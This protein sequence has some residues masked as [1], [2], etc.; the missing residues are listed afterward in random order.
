MIGLRIKGYKLIETIPYSAKDRVLAFWV[1]QV[2]R[3]NVR[4][5]TY[6]GRR[7]RRMVAIYVRS[8]RNPICVDCG[9]FVPWED[10]IPV[11]LDS[12][13]AY[14]CQSCFR[15]YAYRNPTI[16]ETL[17]GK[18]KGLYEQFH[19]NPP[20]RTRKVKIRV[21]NKGE[22]LVAIGKLVSVEY[23][24][25][26]SSRRRKVRYTHELGDTGSRVLPE[27]P[28]LATGKDGKGLFV[29]EDKSSPK[30]SSRGIV[31]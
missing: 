8:A 23:E 30:F 20:M 9:G 24:P 4:A 31:G 29:I 27:K 14:V 15:S 21:P 28:I 18:P 19:G 22:K 13:R 16:F 7:A 26:G 12:K 3:P 10:A 11:R 2:G 5:F 17:F 1:K 6:I 25:Y